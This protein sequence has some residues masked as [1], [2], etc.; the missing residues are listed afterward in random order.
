[1]G[2]AGLA[3]FLSLPLAILAHIRRKYCRNFQWDDFALLLCVVSTG[4]FSQ[5]HDILYQRILWFML[6]LLAAN[7]IRMSDTL[8]RRE[9]AIY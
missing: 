6:G 5:A 3:L 8:S 4:V 9:E 2:L 7:K 1:M